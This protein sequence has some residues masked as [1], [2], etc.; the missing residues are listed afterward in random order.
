MQIIRT[1]STR[2]TY[3][4]IPAAIRRIQLVASSLCEPTA[5]PMKKPR[6]ADK[7]ERKFNR[8]ACHHL[9]PVDNKMT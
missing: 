4:K 2:A 3:I 8:R 1:K 9:S 5:T 6:I 7:E